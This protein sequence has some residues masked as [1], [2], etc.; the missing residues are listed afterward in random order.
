MTRYTIEIGDTSGNT[1]QLSV[2]LDP[3]SAG[4]DARGS[5]RSLTK[6]MIKHHNGTT[7]QDNPPDDLTNMQLALWSAVFDNY[8]ISLDN[9]T[10]L[11]AVNDEGK[12]RLPQSWAIGLSPGDIEWA[13]ID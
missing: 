12:G 6:G 9:F 2:N 5:W 13:I 11:G 1:M 8:A 4:P 7:S 3:T 10:T